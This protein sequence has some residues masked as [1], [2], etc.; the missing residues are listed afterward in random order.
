V[1]YEIYSVIGIHI[2]RD[3]KNRM[4]KALKSGKVPAEYYEDDHFKRRLNFADAKKDILFFNDIG[5]Y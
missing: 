1:L 2:P 4:D 5:Q 3:W